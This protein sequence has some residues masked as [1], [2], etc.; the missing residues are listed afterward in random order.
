M[1]R[2]VLKIVSVALPII[3]IISW[4]IISA[5]AADQPGISVNINGSDANPGTAQ[6]LQLLFLLT[7]L[8]LAPSI[9]LMM[10]SF[11]RIVVV[12]SFVRTGLGLQQTPPNQV[13]I[14]LSLFLTLFIMSPVVTQ[15]NKEA[16]QPFAAGKITQEQAVDAALKPMRTFM[17]KQTSTKEMQL[18]LKL[19]N[20]ESIKNYDDIPTEALIPAFVLSELKKAFIMGFMILIPFLIIDMVVASTLMSMGMIMVPPSMISLPFKLILFV[21]VDGW[22][23]VVKTLVVSFTT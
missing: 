17:L 6:S 10:T 11:T 21:V 23:L 1:K 4:L 3:C 9:I 5:S 7:V 15:V 22:S 8:S 13:L 2:K 16:Y 14:G 12:M 18:F 20:K 19:S